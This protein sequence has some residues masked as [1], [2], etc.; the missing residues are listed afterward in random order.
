M[1]VRYVRPVDAQAKKRRRATWII[2]AI[3]VALLVVCVVLAVKIHA[4]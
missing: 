3:E 2:T 4:V 1:K